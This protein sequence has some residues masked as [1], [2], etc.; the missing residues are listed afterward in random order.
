[1]STDSH[2]GFLGKCVLAPMVRTGE[3]PTRILAL[4]YGADAVWGPEI[5]DKGIIGCRR[6]DNSIADCVDFVKATNGGKGEDRIIFRT[7][8]TIEKNKLIFQIGT[9]SPEL[10]VEGA[11][12]V[13]KDVAGIDVNAGC[14][15]HFSIHSGMGAALLQTPDKLVSILSSLVEE[16][17][18]PNNIPISV[19]I[20]ILDTPE[21]TLDLVRQLCTTGIVRVTVHCRTTPMRP[22]EPVIRDTLSDIVNVCH[23]AGVKCYANG[24]VESRQHAEKLIEEY[25]VDGCMIARAAESNPSV[26]RS[27]GLLDWREVAEEYLKTAVSIGHY[28]S[29]TKFCL[30]HLIP[31]KNP[32]YNDVTRSKTL[33]QM[34]TA[35]GIPCE[36]PFSETEVKSDRTVSK[37]T[38]KAQKTSETVKAAGGGGGARQKKK[39]KKL[40]ERGVTSVTIA[41]TNNEVPTP[42]VAMV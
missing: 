20:R 32:L 3:L 28:V 16:V 26:F 5:V 39:T 4:K 13:A 42:A 6:V 22:R 33:E 24:D 41:E 2:P 18:K 7:H 36:L 27:E 38:K 25:G 19:K 30:G 34:C 23:A 40:S 12:I 31:G 1:M 37:A 8:K 35:L 15:K 10:A 17:G 29:N 21:A 14:P 11:K 9:S